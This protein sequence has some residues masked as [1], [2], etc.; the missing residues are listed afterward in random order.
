MRKALVSA[1][2]VGAALCCADA[3]AEDNPRCAKYQ[4][5]LAYN[6]C[7]ASLG[8]HARGVRAM[9]DPDGQAKADSSDAPRGDGASQTRHGRKRLEF[10]VKRARKN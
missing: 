6:A 9:P 4:E 10:D 7:L 5:P 3:R 1:L 8:P 2:A